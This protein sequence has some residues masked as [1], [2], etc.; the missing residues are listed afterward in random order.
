MSKA[1]AARNCQPATFGGAAR[2]VKMP[3]SPSVFDI[4]VRIVLTLLAAGAIGYERGTHGKAA[5]MRTTLLVALAACLAM[6][7]VNLLL[8]IDGKTPHSFAVLDLMRL[9]LGILTGVGF[10]GAG[11]IL[12]RGAMVIGLTTAATMWFVTVIGLLFGGG[13]IWLGIVGT[14]LGLG[15][16][17]GLRLIET[18]LIRDR[19]ATLTVRID[20]RRVDGDA[21]ERLVSAPPFELVRMSYALTTETQIE[22]RN[23]HLRWSTKAG[24]RELPDVLTRIGAEDGVLNVR[25][26]GGGLVDD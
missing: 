6:L 2:F 9:P 7:Q 18:R 5:G 17:Q 26:E 4:A 19:Q 20:R 16:I 1:A 12:K 21:I 24:E 14:I 13:Q 22:E 15:V 23:F 3:L 10:I 25:W 8:P 11:A